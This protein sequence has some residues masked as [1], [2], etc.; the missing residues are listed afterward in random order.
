MDG[1][2]SASLKTWNDEGGGR[3]GGKLRPPERGH[4][5]V[6]Y[7]VLTFSFIRFRDFWR[8]DLL[9]PVPHYLDTAASANFSSVR[10]N[11]RD[12]IKCPEPATANYLHHSK[13]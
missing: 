8:L 6:P 4:G 2:I 12:E 11:C 9:L 7:P 10:V 1:R 3:V 5:R 13:T